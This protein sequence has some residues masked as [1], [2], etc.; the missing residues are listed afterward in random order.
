M[1]GIISLPPLLRRSRVM[2]RVFPSQLLPLV[3]ILPLRSQPSRRE[4]SSEKFLET[5]NLSGDY[6]EMMRNRGALNL[7]DADFR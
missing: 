3:R 4:C 2:L 7:F 6:A 5:N 1:Q